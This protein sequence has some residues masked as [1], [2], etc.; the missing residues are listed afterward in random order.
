MEYLDPNL[1]LLG[2]RQDRSPL[3][4]RS[5]KRHN[6]LKTVFRFGTAGT[7]G[8]QFSEA[9]RV[10][11]N[12]LGRKSA[13]SYFA[14]PDNLRGPLVT[15]PKSPKRKIVLLEQK[16]A[17]YGI[18]DEGFA[19]EDLETKP[20]K[21]LVDRA[22]QKYAELGGRRYKEA[23]FKSTRLPRL[24]AATKLK[25]HAQPTP[26]PHVQTGR[27]ALRLTPTYLPYFSV[28]GERRE[29]TIRPF[30][31]LAH[32]SATHLYE[33]PIRLRPVEG[34]YQTYRKKNRKK[35]PWVR[36]PAG[37]AYYVNDHYVQRFLERHNWSTSD[38]DREDAAMS[39]FNLPLKYKHVSD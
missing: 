11:E 24:S 19:Y 38:E 31:T 12:I 3:N 27:R 13:D 33:T 17:F 18:Y 36:D 37:S 7:T 20:R 26:R 25:V 6:V 14:A 21:R 8:T 1:Q 34:L 29:G 5:R 28:V 32:T 23:S 10:P 2:Y 35:R 22:R 39:E 9:V 30:R 15:I 4:L 16:R